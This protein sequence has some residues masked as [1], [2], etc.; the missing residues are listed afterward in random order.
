MRDEKYYMEKLLSLP[1]QFEDAVN[2]HDWFKAKYIYD[3]AIRMA[4]FLEADKAIVAQLFQVREEPS[5]DEI[6]PAFDRKE[7]ERVMKE[8]CVKR[9]F[10]HER[11]IKR[12]PG[13]MVFF[14]G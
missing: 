7:V 14:N 8:C 5:G 3:T 11:I 13:E 12:I 6:E 10:G 9:S 4:V 1:Q 2:A